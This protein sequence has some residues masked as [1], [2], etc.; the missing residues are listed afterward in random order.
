M[1]HYWDKKQDLFKCCEDYRFGM[2]LTTVKN[3][4]GCRSC[5]KKYGIKK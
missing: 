2:P 1:I 4:V 3:Y 5:L